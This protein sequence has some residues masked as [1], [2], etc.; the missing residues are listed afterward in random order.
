VVKGPVKKI[1]ETKE[2]ERD[3][4]KYLYEEEKRVTFTRGGDETITDEDLHNLQAQDDC[5]Q[6]IEAQEEEDE[7]DD[8]SNEDRI[9]TQ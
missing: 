9:V 3:R 1:P 2:E 5:K 4:F 8:I 6:E 7:D